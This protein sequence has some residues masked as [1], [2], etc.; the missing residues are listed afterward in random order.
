MHL[1]LPL[2]T[3]LAATVPCW[4]VLLLRPTIVRRDVRLPVAAVVLVFGASLIEGSLPAFF[5]SYRVK[6]DELRLESPYIAQ[7]IALT[8]YGFGLDASAA[9]PFPANGRSRRR[10]SPPMTPPSRTCAGGIRGRCSTPIGSCRRSASTTTFNDVDIDRYT[11]DG[12]YQQVMLSARELDQSR[13]PADAQ[14]WI[15]QHFKFTHG[16]GL[17]MSPVNR[18]D[19]EGPADLLRQGH[20]ARVVGRTADRA[21]AKSTSA[22]RRPATSS[23]AAER[24]SSTTRRARTTSTRPT[25]APT[26]S[27][28]GSLWRRALFA[29][30]LGDIK[31]LISSNITASSRILF[32]RLHCR[33]ASA[34]SRRFSMLDR[35]P[36]LVVSDGRLVWLQD[37]YTTSD[38]LPYSQQAGGRHQLHPQRGQDRRRRLRRH[39]CTSTSPTPHDPIVRTYQRIFPSLF[40]PLERLPPALREHLRYPEDLFVLQAGMYGTYHM[41]D[42]EVFYNKED[43]WSIPEESHGGR[44]RAHGAVL[45]DHA[46]ARRGATRSSS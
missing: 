2:L 1:R 4:P 24:T 35:D 23:S 19:A 9:K 26:A 31:L 45:H 29:W 46:P 8:R 5:Q 41:T 27:A 13:L 37:A 38:A 6:P 39:A 21:A 40:Q 17:A 28:L 25:R 34:A 22:R 7:N 12:T 32:R 14:T 30:H 44:T 33:S 16:I 20:S 3:V 11:L 18:F 42:P 36:Y 10:C 43:L 15:N